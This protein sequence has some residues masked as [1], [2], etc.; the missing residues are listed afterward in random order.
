L[1][2]KQA[3]SSIF[4]EALVRFYKKKAVSVV[5]NAVKDNIFQR[6]HEIWLLLKNGNAA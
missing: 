5:E 3:S 2:I 1:R 4:I 6:V